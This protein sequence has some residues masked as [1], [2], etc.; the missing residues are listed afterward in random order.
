MGL[1]EIEERGMEW[2]HLAQWRT[3]L[4]TLMNIWVPQNVDN[5]FSG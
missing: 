3:L 4:N 5:S 1:E 2:I